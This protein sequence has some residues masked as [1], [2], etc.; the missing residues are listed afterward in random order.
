MDEF[1]FRDDASTVV[2][3]NAGAGDAVKGFYLSIVTFHCF[4]H[5]AQPAG[6]L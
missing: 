5:Q 6:F 4:F 1:G 3:S 2:K